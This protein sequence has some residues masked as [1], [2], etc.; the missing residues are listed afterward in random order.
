MVRSTLYV[1]GVYHARIARPQ[2]RV[3]QNF[4]HRSYNGCRDSVRPFA[5]GRHAR[6]LNGL[7]FFRATSVDTR[8]YIPGNGCP[9]RFQPRSTFVGRVNALRE[10][11]IR[12]DDNADILSRGES[13]RDISGQKQPGRIRVAHARRNKTHDIFSRRRY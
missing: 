5:D 10:R 9:N 4:F 3:R 1:F 13:A 12:Y 7:L 11:G 6:E 2:N 8:A